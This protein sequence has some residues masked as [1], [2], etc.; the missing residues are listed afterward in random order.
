MPPWPNKGQLNILNPWAAKHGQHVSLK[1]Y[2][3]GTAGQD[4]QP[5]SPTKSSNGEGQYSRDCTGGLPQGPPG[6]CQVPEVTAI[7]LLTSVFVTDKD[8]QTEIRLAISYEPTP[9][10]WIDTHEG[11]ANCQPSFW[12]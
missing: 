1:P 11:C 12:G 2:K 7:K 4:N 3:Q 8:P 9:N 10:L 6:G 5:L